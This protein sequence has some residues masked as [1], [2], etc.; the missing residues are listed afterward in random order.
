MVLTGAGAAFSGGGDIKWASAHPRGLAA[1]FH[2]LAT[3]V[4]LSIAEIRRMRKPVIAAVNG[5][6]AGG[7]FS[8]ALACDFRVMSANAVLK[9]GYTSSGLCID[10]GGTFDG[11][12]A[13]NLVATD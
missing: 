12:S 11:D 10:A 1:A 8:L 13:L 4:H 3:H 7:G 2:E 6:A 9:Q 5:V